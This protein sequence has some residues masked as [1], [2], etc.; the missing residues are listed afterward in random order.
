MIT[1]Y[2]VAIAPDISKLSGRVNELI[3]DGWQPWG[4]LVISEPP[5]Y[6]Y[7]PMVRYAKDTNFIFD[8]SSTPPYDLG[9]GGTPAGM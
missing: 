2:C 4:N 8:F 1:E 3:A 9:G 6:V 5:S 7:Q